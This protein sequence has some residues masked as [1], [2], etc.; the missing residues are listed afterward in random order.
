MGCEQG[1]YDFVGD[2]A[3]SMG[4]SYSAGLRRLALIGARCE[5]EHGKATMP[6]SYGELFRENKDPG[7]VPED[8]FDWGEG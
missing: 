8:E 7:V 5:A 6:A 3:K 4:M 1:L 2:Y